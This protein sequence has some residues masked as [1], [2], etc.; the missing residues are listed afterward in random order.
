[1][2]SNLGTFGVQAAQFNN[3]AIVVHLTLGDARR[4]HH[5]LEHGHPDNQYNTITGL[6]E[7]LRD[8]LEKVDVHCDDLG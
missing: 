4:L 5:V 2:E 8:E 3:D 7:R 6:I 1:M